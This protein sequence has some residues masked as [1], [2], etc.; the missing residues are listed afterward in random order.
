MKHIDEKK[1]PRLKPIYQYAV[2]DPTSFSE[3]E[4]R[5]AFQQVD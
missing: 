4:A 5:Y 2:K 1:T 3:T